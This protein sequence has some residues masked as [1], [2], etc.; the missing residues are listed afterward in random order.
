MDGGAAGVW[1]A[2]PARGGAADAVNGGAADPAGR[3]GCAQAGRF[4]KK[5]GSSSSA[6]NN[7]GMMF[8]LI[9]MSILLTLLIN[10]VKKTPIR[11]LHQLTGKADSGEGV[12]LLK[13]F[14]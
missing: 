2:E 10:S 3:A 9:F 12:C 4:C 13:K 14:S 7:L 8:C 1:A 5:A 11:G 6:K